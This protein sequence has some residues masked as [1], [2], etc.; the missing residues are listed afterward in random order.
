MNVAGIDVGLTL[1]DRTSGV[2]R[3]VDQG[4]VLG[5][6]YIDRLSRLQALG[7]DETSFDVLAIDAPLP[8]KK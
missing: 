3:T 7:G 4:E 5:H 6:T 2:C 8:A 1:I